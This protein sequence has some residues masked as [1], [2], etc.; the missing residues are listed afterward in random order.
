[1]LDSQLQQIIENPG[2][3]KQDVNYA[4]FLYIND[5]V[6]IFVGITQKGIHR[7]KLKGVFI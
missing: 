4:D 5:K 3:R 7:A 1:M 6:E 2:V